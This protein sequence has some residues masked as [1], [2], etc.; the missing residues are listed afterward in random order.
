[1]PSIHVSGTKMAVQ[2][3]K[4]AG[5]GSVFGVILG[6]GYKVAVMDPA[7]REVDNYYKAQASPAK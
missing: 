6:V 5:I 7:K 4:Q 1:M 2:I 3:A